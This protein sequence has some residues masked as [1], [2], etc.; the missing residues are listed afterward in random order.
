MK[1]IF[2]LTLPFLLCF[3]VFSQSGNLLLPIKVDYKWGYCNQDGKIVIEPQYD[4]AENFIC[5]LS[6]VKLKG[7][8]GIVDSTGKTIIEPKEEAVNIFCPHYISIKEDSVWGL[9]DAE[10]NRLIDPQFTTIELWAEDLFIIKK[11][12]LTGIYDA[13]TKT[14][15][16]PIYTSISKV[17][18]FYVVNIEGK[19]GLLDKSFK[20]LIE[21]QYIGLEILDSTSILV[22]AKDFWAVSYAYGVNITKFDFMAFKKI[23]QEFVML[24]A[25]I[26]GW[27]L[28]NLRKRKIIS[29]EP[30]ENYSL[31]DDYLIMTTKY[32]KHGLMDGIGNTILGLNYSNIHK[33]DDYLLVE[34]DGKW[35]LTTKE[36]NF[37]IETVHDRLFPFRKNLA[38]FETST[39]KG[40]ININGKILIKPVF[41]EVNIKD[42]LAVCKDNEGNTFNLSLDGKSKVINVKTKG[43]QIANSSTS[44][45]HSWLRGEGRKWGLVGND[46]IF[47]PFKF[48]EVIIKGNYALAGNKIDYRTN[49]RMYGYL[50]Q[51]KLIELAN[52]KFDLVDNISGKILHHGNNIWLFRVE[53][54]ETGENA[55]M[56][57]EGGLQAL[58]S[59]QGKIIQDYSFL[60]REKRMVRN[61]FSY[62]GKFNDQIANYCVGGTMNYAGDWESAKVTGGKWGYIHQNGKF[63]SEPQFEEA[64]PFINGRAIVKIKGLYGVIDETGAYVIKPTLS[65]I[66]F[67]ENSNNNYLKIESKKDRFGL[68]DTLG[69]LLTPISYDKIFPFKEGKARIMVNGKYGFIDENHLVAVQPIY[70]NALDFSEGFAAICLGKL[71]GFINKDGIQEIMPMSPSVG[72]YKD[73][74]APAAR[75]GKMTYINKD[76]RLIVV[77][78]YAYASEFYNGMAIVSTDGKKRGIIDGKAKTLLP[79]EYD[80]IQFLKKSNL[81]KIKQDGEWKLMNLR[82]FKPIT[83]KSY[84]EIGE[85][86]EDLVLARAE[87]NYSYLD[88]NG[89][90]VINKKFSSAFAFSNG[91]ARAIQDNKTGFINLKGNTIVNFNYTT[92]TDFN[93]NHAF[94]LT[95]NKLWAI[96]N[97]NGKNVTSGIFSNPKPFSNNV[98]LISNGK[99]YFFVDTLGN[100]I[101][102]EKFELAY[103]F[104]FGVARVKSNKWGLLNVKGYHYVENK[105]DYFSEFKDNQAVIGLYYSVGIADLDGNY[106]V[107]PSFD[108]VFG[109]SDKVFRAE[110]SD[111]VGY[112][113]SDKT[114]IWE[115]KK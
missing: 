45:A 74:I 111:A 42:K 31:I 91:L 13:K 59:K 68:I 51:Q 100:N 84:L 19:L 63:L 17:K 89:K 79:E 65:N 7:K 39:G 78:K 29:A 75:D 80:D 11:D 50:N 47:V 5:K 115:L 90:A 60:S 21:P 87:K 44:E 83:K 104:E 55:K 101:S 110:Q 41:I 16:N 34:K 52:V 49:P 64:G 66:T 67:L 9:D 28:Y 4:Y 97:K 106:I 92:C 20:T 32:N 94:T 23:D 15:I 38:V 14:L 61:P 93:N 53:D 12:N 86:S 88:S 57:Y 33:N 30:H 18:N 71:W 36:G 37:I 40:V 8:F 27:H 2:T 81:A 98:S 102:K 107:E 22:K 56:I 103:P 113:R 35:G 3:S 99:D 112:L 69:K 46:T 109:I 6:K 108:N 48:D 62:I 105:Y 24:K 85:F 26:G 43:Y 96:I 25:K 1:L 114:F 70:D 58:I 72:N 82:T 10:G 54:F 73:G 95:D 76:G 77:P